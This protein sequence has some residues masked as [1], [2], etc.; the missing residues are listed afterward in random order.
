MARFERDAY[1]DP[2]PDINFDPSEFLPDE[3]EAE[4]EEEDEPDADEDEPGEPDEDLGPAMPTELERMRETGDWD[5]CV[6]D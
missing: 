4:P 6:I 5:C 3:D 1:G 2:Y